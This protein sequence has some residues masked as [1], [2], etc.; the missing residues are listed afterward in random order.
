MIS[1]LL[2]KH[3]GYVVTQSI[4]RQIDND[5]N[6]MIGDTGESIAML[7]AT[8]KINED[9]ITSCKEDIKKSNKLISTA[10]YQNIILTGIIARLS[11]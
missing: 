4:I 7:E 8:I 1:K 9:I 11:K 6:K 5:F 3:T 10:E 2:E